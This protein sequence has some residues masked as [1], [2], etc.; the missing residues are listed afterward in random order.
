MLGVNEHIDRVRSPHGRV[1]ALISGAGSTMAAVLNAQQD[2][3]YGA[4]IIGVVADTP[5][6]GG[7][8]V[9]RDAGIATAVVRPTDF[10][11]R[12][13]WNSALARTVAAFSPDL[14]LSAGFMRILGQPFL[15]MFGGRT[16][17][18]HPALLPSFPGAH[19]VRDALAYGVK[20][21]GCTLHVVDGGVDT[22]PIIAQVPVQIEPGEDESALHER[23][24]V[25]ERSLLVTWVPRLATG[26]IEITGRAASV[27]Q[28]ID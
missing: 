1:V 21:T 5:D 10:A 26:R 22:G 17:N 3:G 28:A 16:V 6:A 14:V 19:A 11:T 20:V 2:S 23:I 24:K 7:L 8:A 12:D 13:K 9:A 15:D 25:A 18:T 27:V 4:R